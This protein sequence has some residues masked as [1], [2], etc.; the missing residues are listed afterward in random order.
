MKI[1]L[2]SV[3]VILLCATLCSAQT[4]DK[5]KLSAVSFELGKT[6]L[7]YNVNFDHKLASKN[8]GFRLGAGSNFGQYLS[9]ISVGGGGYHLIGRTKNFFELGLDIQYLIADE[10]SDDQ[11]DFASIFVYPDYSTKTIYQSLNFGYRR[12]G[13]NTMFRVGLSPGIIKG[14]LIPGGYIS[15]GFSF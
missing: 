14:E 8:F 10:V 13:K 1:Y 3:V 9:V 6:G 5:P 4:T 2:A 12:Y 11:K 7:I 15:C